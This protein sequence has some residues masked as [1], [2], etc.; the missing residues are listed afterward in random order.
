M[1]YIQLDGNLNVEFAN[2]YLGKRY[3]NQDAKEFLQSYKDDNKLEI[4]QV[5][6]KQ[7]ANL[8]SKGEIVGWLN[9]RMEFGSRALGARSIIANPNDEAVIQKINDQVKRRDFWMPFTPTMLFEDTY[10]FIINKK[11]LFF[12]YSIC[13]SQFT[14]HTVYPFA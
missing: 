2:P 11:K 8:L 5:N 10:K 9:G 1:S 13:P 12:L 14:K 6:L 7:V 3:C 4:K